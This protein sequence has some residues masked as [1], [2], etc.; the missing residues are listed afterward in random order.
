MLISNLDDL[1]GFL[2]KWYGIADLGL[3]PEAI[4]SDIIVPDV[5]RQFWIRVG[6]LSVGCGEWL[7][8]GN[9]SPLACQDGIVAPGELYV[10]EGVAQVVLENQGNWA[11]GYKSEDQSTDPEVFSDFLEQVQGG[12]GFVQLGCKLSNLVITSALT[13]TII[14]GSLRAKNVKEL[15]ANCDQTI[16]TGHYYNAV[17]QGSDYEVPSHQIRTNSDQ[18]LLSL[19]WDGEFSGFVASALNGRENLQPFL[20]AQR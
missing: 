7:L 5:L 13:E 6:R 9:P 14:F 8:S 3:R 17:G 1:S 12:T 4:P 20:H 19:Y 11:I 18:S 16:W 15:A 2:E 10:R